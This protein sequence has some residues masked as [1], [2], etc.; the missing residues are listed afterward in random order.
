MWPVG[1]AIEQLLDSPEKRDELK[2]RGLARAPRYSVATIA[3]QYDGLLSLAGRPVSRS[4]RHAV[5]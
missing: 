5:P 2:S 3:K 4:R 1:R